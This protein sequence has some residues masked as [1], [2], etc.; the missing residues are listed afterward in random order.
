MARRVPHQS[1]SSF[2]ILTQRSMLALIVAG[3]MKSALKPPASGLSPG[4]LAG[5]DGIAGR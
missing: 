1:N 5:T 4:V 2:L 3:E